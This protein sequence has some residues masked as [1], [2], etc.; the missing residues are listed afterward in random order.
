MN[1]FSSEM[2]TTYHAYRAIHDLDPNCSDFIA[3]ATAFDGKYETAV[4]AV[5]VQT[6]GAALSLI[7][8]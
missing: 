2:M 4:Q 8:I 7:H 3:F 5:S 1:P 6:E